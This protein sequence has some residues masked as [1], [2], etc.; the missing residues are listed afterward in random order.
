MF[1]TPRAHSLSIGRK[2]RRAALQSEW[3]SPKMPSHGR[4]SGCQGCVTTLGRRARH[5]S[6]FGSPVKAT[7]CSTVYR[8][9]CKVMTSTDTERRRREKELVVCLVLRQGR[10]AST[11]DSTSPLLSAD[12]PVAQ[13]GTSTSTASHG[14]LCEN[15]CNTGSIVR[16]GTRLV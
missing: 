2:V 13:G 1:S 15:L 14:L 3:R 9:R 12:S 5:S 6:C 16:L 10:S 7:R 11:H 8:C 4:E